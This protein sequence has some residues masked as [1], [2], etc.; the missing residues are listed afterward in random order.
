MYAFKINT[1]VLFP[2]TNLR[3]EKTRLKI[4]PRTFC[5]SVLVLCHFKTSSQHHSMTFY[6]IHSATS[7]TDN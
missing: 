6:K 1:F 2:R 3:N 5:T 4:S 7:I